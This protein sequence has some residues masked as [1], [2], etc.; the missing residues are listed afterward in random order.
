MEAMFIRSLR[1]EIRIHV[2]RMGCYTFEEMLNAAQN[3]WS[4]DHNEADSPLR[5]IAFPQNS[6]VNKVSE[7]N[8]ATINLPNGNTNQSVNGTQN[9]SNI[10]DLIGHFENLALN[11]LA[12]RPPI[13]CN[14][15]GRYGHYAR[16]CRSNRPRPPFRNNLP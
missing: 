8:N 5:A 16:D 12:Y 3:H 10:T 14:N 1:P 7:E 13:T 9:G 4:A 15:C 6:I 11:R 2:K